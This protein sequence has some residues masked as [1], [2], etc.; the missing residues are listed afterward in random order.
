MVF[1]STK[2]ITTFTGFGI[3]RSHIRILTVSLSLERRVLLGS[4]FSLCT[5]G[6]ERLS[7]VLSVNFMPC[8]NC[9]FP[10]S[11]AITF[12]HR[13]H[14]PIHAIVKVCVVVHRDRVD[15]HRDH[16]ALFC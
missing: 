14:G 11:G 5:R 2:Y 13:D 15:D 8:E 9:W 4:I 7:R 16:K 10:T 12:V 6:Y 3:R 1:L